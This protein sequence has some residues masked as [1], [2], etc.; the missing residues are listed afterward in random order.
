M[1]CGVDNLNPAQRGD[2]VADL[3]KQPQGGVARIAVS[4][5]A[6]RKRTELIQRHLPRAKTYAHPDRMQLFNSSLMHLTA[7]L[8]AWCFSHP[9][10]RKPSVVRPGFVGMP[11]RCCIPY[12]QRPYVVR[13]THPILCWVRT[14]TH[15]VS[16]SL[17]PMNR[18]HQAKFHSYNAVLLKVK[19]LD[20]L[21][22]PTG[23]DEGLGRGRLVP[24]DRAG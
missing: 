15:P 21:S 14:H 4:S 8:R 24:G 9:V 13:K 3:V 6:A 22:D 12:G 11:D 2:R 5:G 18:S 19:S 20:A 1:L 17:A 23:K 16:P 7:A 10:G